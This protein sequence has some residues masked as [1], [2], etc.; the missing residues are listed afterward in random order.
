MTC[1][2]TNNGTCSQNLQSPRA[3]FVNAST[4]E[5]WIANSGQSTCVRFPQFN[6]LITNNAP[7]GAVTAY[8]PLSLA[9]DQYGDL[10]VADSANRVSA[11]YQGTA[12]END[13]SFFS[14]PLAPGSVAALYPIATVN[15]FGSITAKFSGSFPIATTLGG[16][17]V[18]VGGTP[19]PLYYVSPGQINFIVPMNTPGS[20]TADVVVAQQSTARWAPASC[21]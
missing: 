10:F 3:V 20:G 7:T 11:Y 17:Q 12:W 16:V 2:T 8:G 9:Q 13:A 19:A 6:T 18:L 14:A 15:Q 5:I 4:G 1:A 21:P